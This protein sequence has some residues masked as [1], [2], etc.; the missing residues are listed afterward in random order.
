[1]P[2]D[3]PDPAVLAATSAAVEAVWPRPAPPAEPSAAPLSSWRFS[4]RWWSGPPL[5]RRDRP[6]R[7]G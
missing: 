3:Q 7:I 5:A 2:T 4:G 6:S 1:M